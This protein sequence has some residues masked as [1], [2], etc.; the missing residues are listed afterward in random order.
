M[1]LLQNLHT[2]ST[3]CDGKHTPE[4]LISLAQQKGFT[5][6]GFSGHCPMWYSAY[7]AITVETNEAYKREITALKQ[8]YKDTFPLFLGLEVDMYSGV[9]MTGYD[10]LIGAVHYLKIG[11]EFVGFDRDATVVQDVI[12]THFSGDGLAFAK[13]YYEA[14]AQLPQYGTFDIL[15]HFDLLVKNLDALQMFDEQDPRYVGYALEAMHALKGKIPLFEV[16]TGAM[17]RGYRQVPYPSLH[18]MR[19]LKQC[20][21]GAI[22]SSDCHDGAALDVGFEQSAE[23]LKAAGFTERYILTDTGFQAVAL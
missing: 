1:E 6:L 15:G 23:L 11:D 4:E 19:E 2:H 7:K 16:N 8:K 9:D 10:Y 21:F 22:I 17:A 3:F 5:S 14:L 13:A 20:G 12:D 18:L